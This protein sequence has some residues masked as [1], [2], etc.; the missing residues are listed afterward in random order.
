VDPVKKKNPVIEKARSE[1]YNTGFKNGFEHGKYSACVV[2]ADKMEGLDKVA[3]IGPKIME[4]I[5]HHFGK[6]YFEER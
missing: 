5:V 1:G 4:K 6:E 3:G 2:F